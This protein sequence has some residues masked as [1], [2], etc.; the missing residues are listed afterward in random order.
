MPPNEKQI[1]Q[2]DMLLLLT[3]LEM[4]V[5]NFLVH[6]MKFIPHISVVHNLFGGQ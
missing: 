2:R 4:Q 6:R 5:G 1:G 3:S